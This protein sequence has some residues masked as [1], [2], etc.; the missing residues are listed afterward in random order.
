MPN[1]DDLGQN[2]EVLEF[3]ALCLIDGLDQNDEGL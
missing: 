2:N 1:F 3:K